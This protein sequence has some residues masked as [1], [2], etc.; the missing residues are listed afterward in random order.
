MNAYNLDGYSLSL[1]I[2]FFVCSNSVFST[3]R[4]KFKM[5]NA[6][7]IVTISF[8]N[9]HFPI[10]GKTNKVKIRE[11]RIHNILD[12]RLIESVISL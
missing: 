1:Y 6:K 4:E 9:S 3:A 12:T 10:K 8:P 2:D 7:K 11:M 5:Q